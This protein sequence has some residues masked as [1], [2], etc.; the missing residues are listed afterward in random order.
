MGSMNF[1]PLV[2]FSV[3]A[4]NFAFISGK[5]EAIRQVHLHLTPHLQLKTF[6]CIHIVFLS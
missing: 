3:S 5:M 2:F 6:S 1:L 4:N